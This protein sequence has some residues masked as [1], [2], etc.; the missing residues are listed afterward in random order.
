MPVQGS[1]WILEITCMSP[2]S[3]EVFFLFKKNILAIKIQGNTINTPSGEASYAAI[4]TGTT[5]IGGPSEE[6]AKIFAQ[7]P[8]S[9][10]GTGPYQ[11]YF[12]YRAFYLFIFFSSHLLSPNASYADPRII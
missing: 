6:I 2:F 9:S 1:Y 11:N 7:I 10:P 12:T 5:L 8:G 3:A 4:D